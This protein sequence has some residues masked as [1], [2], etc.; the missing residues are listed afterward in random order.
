MIRYFVDIFCDVC[1]RRGPGEMIQA[2]GKGKRTV[3]N[4]AKKHGWEWDRLGK[5]DICPTCLCLNTKLVD[6]WDKIDE[7]EIPVRTYNALVKHGKVT[8]GDISRL[9]RPQVLDLD[10]IGRLGYSELKFALLRYQ[11]GFRWN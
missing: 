7:L 6:C 5:Q 3:R 2:E 8:I 11:R 9:T 1:G 10:G 4:L